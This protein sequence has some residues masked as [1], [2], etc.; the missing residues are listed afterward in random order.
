MKRVPAII[1]MVE[2]VCEMRPFVFL[3]PEGELEVW[4]Y[5][6]GGYWRRISREGYHALVHSTPGYAG[7]TLLGEL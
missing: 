3:T 6:A 1:K 2:L 5:V 7:R 4:W